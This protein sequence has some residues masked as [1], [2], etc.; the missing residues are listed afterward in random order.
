MC[1]KI[2]LSVYVLAVDDSIDNQIRNWIERINKASADVAKNYKAVIEE[3]KSGR[4]SQE[5]ESK[6]LKNTLGKAINSCA[7]YHQTNRE[8]F[9]EPD[10]E[11]TIKPLHHLEYKLSKV[12]KSSDAAESHDESKTKSSLHLEYVVSKVFKCYI[13]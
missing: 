9:T 3:E 12:V 7:N 11:T 1:Y 8:V 5:S 13:C 2:L 4:C 10:V 6:Q